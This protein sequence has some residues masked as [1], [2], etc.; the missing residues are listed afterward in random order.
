[1]KSEGMLAVKIIKI[2]RQHTPTPRLCSS[3]AKGVDIDSWG[4]SKAW[5]SHT[6][7]CI[8]VIS[9]LFFHTSDSGW[10]TP[11]RSPIN[12][13]NNSTKVM[14]S[15]CFAVLGRF[16]LFLNKF[17][18]YS[19][20][21]VTHSLDFC[22]QPYWLF[23]KLFCI[24]ICGAK[25]RMPHTFNIYIARSN[26][27]SLSS[28]DA[29]LMGQVQVRMEIYVYSDFVSSIYTFPFFFLRQ[30]AWKPFMLLFLF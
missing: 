7:V 14:T 24:R 28:S 4:S 16:F 10:L 8:R 11:L 3:Q 20:A 23:Q 27:V 25:W 21:Q 18:A 22:S 1:M 6:Q 13:Q 2:D 26:L 15:S 30:E 5:G 29:H 9:K 12:L 19:F 17:K